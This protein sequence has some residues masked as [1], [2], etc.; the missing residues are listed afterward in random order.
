[1][2]L[3]RWTR[4][5]RLTFAMRNPLGG[6]GRVP[7]APAQTL[8][9]PWPGNPAVGERL[10]RN[11]AFFEG[12]AHPL[13][14]GQWDSPNW[15]QPYREWLQGFGWL[16]DL[17]ELGAESARVKARSLVATW[18]SIPASERPVSDPAITGAR[19]AAWLSYY[20]FFA[21]TADDHFRQTLMAALIM[22]GR[23][24]IALMPEGA[25]GWRALTA[26]KGLLS[27]A[28]AIPDQ[29]DFL[30]RFLKLIDETINNQFLPDG[31]HKTRN[32][33]N[34]FQA[35]REMAEITSILQIAHLPLPSSLMSVCNRATLVLRA[36][37][38]NDGGLMIFNGSMAREAP[39]VAHI[40]SRASRSNVIAASI[41]DSG[42]MRLASGRTLLLADAGSVA[43][44]GFDSTAHA[45][46]LSFEFSSGKQ[47]IIVN[48][49]SS[50]QRGWAEALRQA[51]AHSVLE[52]KDLSPIDINKAGHVTRR[53]QVTRHP[54][55]QDGAHWLHMTHDGYAQHGGGT[56]MRQLYLG[57]DGQT[58][59]GE[60]TLPGGTRTD[61][62]VRFHLHPDVTI[63]QTENGFLLYTEEESWLFQSD[64]HATIEESVYLGGPHRAP[65]R[66]IVL[67]PIVP[68]PTP[69]T[70]DTEHT[71]HEPG[72]ADLT[73]D[74]TEQAAYLVEEQQLSTTPEDNLQAEH[75]P[76]FYSA[77][78]A[79]S[80][81]TYTQPETYE[82]A[83]LSHTQQ[84]EEHY[85]AEP[86]P[87]VEE[88][89]YAPIPRDPPPADSVPTLLGGV[90]HLHYTAE[91][92]N[93]GT[94][95]TLF[96]EQARAEEA[97][98]R[99][100]RRVEEARAAAAEE[101]SSPLPLA[102]QLANQPMP[103]PPLRW[104]LSLVSE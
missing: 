94:T 42:Y 13:H 50:T 44:T 1:M 49:G 52:F 69:I 89:D 85:T 33:E 58:L 38:H 97:A 7:T 5:A 86:A 102:Q 2:S 83:D 22:E 68:Q 54:T 90:V 96:A 57:P 95:D 9:D 4:E 77:P 53:P 30:S 14:H 32:P 80:Y 48:C 78:E 59:R 81:A 27:V 75:T 73:A 20:D 63:E 8:R 72:E 34:Q 45:G 10:V 100:A 70:E 79:E 24:I 60:E 65:T 26:L 47:R 76:E 66:Q 87:M 88:D 92:T 93:P 84:Q 103:C 19:L 98:A 35:V 62:C 23:S 51:A 104:A 71:E 43:P 91:R 3:R 40:I 55:T 67:T 41:A 36:M 46:M 101:V 28:V 11:Q 25:E 12:V 64:A 56:Y 6:F 37:R 18:I 82:E 21:A 39:W 74:G 29:P 99:Q 61:F 31:S 17:R 15:P 16:R